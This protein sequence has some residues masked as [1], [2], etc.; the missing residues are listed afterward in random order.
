MISEL[1]AQVRESL[2]AYLSAHL[3]AGRGLQ[4]PPLPGFGALVLHPERQLRPGV[5]GH[6]PRAEPPGSLHLPRTA[7]RSWL[8]AQ[9][10]LYEARGSFQVI[11]RRMERYGAGALHAA[12][13]RLKERLESEGLFAA[14]RKR[15][16]P[17]LPQPHRHR[18]QPGWR[19]PARYP[20]HPAPPACRR[21]GPAV[22]HAGAGRRLCPGDRCRH[23]HGRFHDRAGCAHRREGWR[24]PGRSLGLQRRGS[25]PRPGGLVPS[26]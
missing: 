22:P 9:V 23:Q 20:A 8:L 5:G 4:L 7:P 17:G 13:L 1:N 26:P 2:E 21:L 6:V 11:V 3:A 25:G 16:L 18:H 15:P 12:F 10:S 19:R 24:Q 14:D